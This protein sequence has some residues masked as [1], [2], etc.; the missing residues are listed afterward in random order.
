ME[1]LRNISNSYA[2]LIY[3]RIVSSDTVFSFPIQEMTTG[4]SIT[5]TCIVMLSAIFV[6][7]AL[8]KMT[9]QCVTF[10]C[11]MLFRFIMYCASIIN[12]LIQSV[13][14]VIMQKYIQ[15]TNPF[16]YVHIW[17]NW[18]RNKRFRI[19]TKTEPQK[20]THKD[21]Y[22]TLCELA[23]FNENVILNV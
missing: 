10:V 4:V 21:I 23:T 7:T 20:A 8:I 1:T 5:L 3:D 16:E 2:S 17:H 22:K 14:Q 19:L 11:I 9:Y 13:R 18:Y 15:Y 12:C 6:L